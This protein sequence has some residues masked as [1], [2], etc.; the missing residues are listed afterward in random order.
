MN[1]GIRT[2]LRKSLS[3]A[4]VAGSL[5]LA[6]CSSVNTTQS[7]TI[8]I[9]RTQYMSSMVLEQALEQEAGQQSAGILQNVRSQGALER[10]AKQV[11]RV[12]AMCNRLLAQVGPVRPAS[13]NAQH[14][15]TLSS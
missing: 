15:T 6:G 8:G 4:A 5:A 3:A 13:P 11:M 1:A 9:E 10:E 7:G 12:L 14:E 2:V